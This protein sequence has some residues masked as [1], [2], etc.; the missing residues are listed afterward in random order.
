MDSINDDDDII[1]LL[2]SILDCS[3]L[4]IIGPIWIGSRLFR[5]RKHVNCD[6]IFNAVLKEVVILESVPIC[7]EVFALF[8]VTQQLQ[9]QATI[10]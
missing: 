6:V 10:L 5:V 8:T 2:L 4:S 1:P 9:K 7:G 3:L